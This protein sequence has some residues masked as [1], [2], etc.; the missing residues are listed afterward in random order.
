MAC[1]KAQVSSVLGG[2]GKRGA[3]PPLWDGH[4]AGRIADHIL[5]KQ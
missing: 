1:L 4:A 5:G 2:R 3:V